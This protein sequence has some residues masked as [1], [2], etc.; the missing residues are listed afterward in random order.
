MLRFRRCRSF[1]PARGWAVLLLMTAVG[2][3]AAVPARAG[4][5]AK[6]LLAELG[7]SDAIV[8]GKAT[9]LRVDTVESSPV[10]LVKLAVS[11]T[12]RGEVAA[13]IEIVVPRTLI[14]PGKILVETGAQDQPVVGVGEEVLLFLT[15]YP[16]RENSYSILAGEM[17]RYKVTT[18]AA[19]E[20]R[21]DRYV[22][23]A[24]VAGGV[25]LATL[26]GQ[27]RREL[28]LPEKPAIPPQ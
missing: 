15:R 3:V 8:V 23:A 4:D 13:E 7:R 10:S 21:A 11:E 9:S 12:L 19:G 14:Q 17:G 24:P 27:I 28:K 5:I 20:R 25:P 18:N 16:G 1:G 26:I 2:A 6:A 22:L